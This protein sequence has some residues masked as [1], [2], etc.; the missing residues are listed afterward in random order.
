[1]NPTGTHRLAYGSDPGDGAAPRELLA[2][3][4]LLAPTSPHATADAWFLPMPLSCPSGFLEGLPTVIKEGKKLKN[5]LSQLKKE[6]LAAALPQPQGHPSPGPGWIGLAPGH[7]CRDVAEGHVLSVPPASMGL[8]DPQATLPPAAQGLASSKRASETHCVGHVD[9]GVHIAQ[10]V[11]Q[12]H[13]VINDLIKLKGKGVKVPMGF[14][15]LSSPFASPS[16]SVAPPH[17]P[18]GV[19]ADVEHGHG[20]VGCTVARRGGHDVAGSDAG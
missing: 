18:L 19:G 12:A 5:W 2:G 9:F 13:D 16:S 11:I 17:L 20:A 8:R 1:M 3:K 15:A 6:G 4:L 7:R 14:S 10:N